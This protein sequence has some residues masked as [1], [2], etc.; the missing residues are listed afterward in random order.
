MNEGKWSPILS[1]SFDRD[2]FEVTPVGREL[3]TKEQWRNKV[4]MSRIIFEAL[5]PPGAEPPVKI[6]VEDPRHPNHQVRKPDPNSEP[7]R[8]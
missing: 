5:A 3:M 8:S 6:Y 7:D 1:H 2:G 4:E